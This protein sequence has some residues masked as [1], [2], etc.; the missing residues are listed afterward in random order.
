MTVPI[1]N[2]GTNEEPMIVLRDVH[3]WYGTFHVLKGIN[4]EIKKGER[5][6][7]IRTL[8]HTNETPVGGRAI[9]RVGTGQYL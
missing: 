2:H 9:E 3:K 7:Y 8:I 4:L 5:I 1:T 6:V